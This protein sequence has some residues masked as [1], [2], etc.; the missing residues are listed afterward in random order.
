M[1]L[2]GC[3]LGIGVTLACFHSVGSLQSRKDWLKMAQ[4]G[5]AI[6]QERSLRIQLGRSSG[7]V[8]IFMLV[9]ISFKSTSLSDII[10]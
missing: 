6:V 5:G 8:V 7:P 3:T 9:L 1:D 10:R 2:G 4:I